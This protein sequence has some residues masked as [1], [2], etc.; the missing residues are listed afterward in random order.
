MSN[1]RSADGVGI[2]DGGQPNHDY[3]PLA[4]KALDILFN[5]RYSY[6]LLLCYCHAARPTPT[7][8]R[9]AGA[10][11]SRSKRNEDGGYGRWNIKNA[12]TMNNE[13]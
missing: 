10:C 6:H 11:R 7:T 2:F 8:R 4:L 5:S 3:S 13:V 1:T 12:T 9:R